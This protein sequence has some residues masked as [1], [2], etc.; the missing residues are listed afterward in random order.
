MKANSAYA[1][2]AYDFQQIPENKE[3]LAQ[4]IIGLLP[5]KVGFERRAFAYL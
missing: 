1:K 4:S 3:F 2:L 5:L